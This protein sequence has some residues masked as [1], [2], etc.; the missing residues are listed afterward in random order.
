MQSNGLRSE[1][2]CLDMSPQ[3]LD[4]HMKIRFVYSVSRSCLSLSQQFTHLLSSMFCFLFPSPLFSC[5]LLSHSLR[6]Q[7]VAHLPYATDF[8]FRIYAF[9][10]L[11]TLDSKK[12]PPAPGACTLGGESGGEQDTSILLCLVLCYSFPTTKSLS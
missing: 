6:S 9:T 7:A 12:T 4:I 1:L 2:S 3:N 11:Q 8:R 10:T 5:H